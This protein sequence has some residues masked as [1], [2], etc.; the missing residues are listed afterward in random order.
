[1]SGDQRED[2]Y[3]SGNWP[4]RRDETT[5]EDVAKIAAR[6][7]SRPETATLDEIKKLAASALTQ[8]KPK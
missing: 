5:S 1:M 4:E 3:N 7:L 2:L 8:R 6:V